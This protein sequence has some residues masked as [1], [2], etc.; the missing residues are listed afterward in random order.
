MTCL[1]NLIHVYLIQGDWAGLHYAK[2]TQAL[3]SRLT[4]LD[5]DMRNS[6]YYK[7]FREIN[8]LNRGA[9][10][11]IALVSMPGPGSAVAWLGKLVILF[12]V[13]NFSSLTPW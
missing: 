5:S 6:F 8:S 3:R 10:V 4:L 12:F 13:T 2:V 1:L 11:K 7:C 9:C